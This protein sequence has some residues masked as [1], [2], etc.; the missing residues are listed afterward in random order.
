LNAFEGK[1]NCCF[2]DLLY[3]HCEH[4]CKSTQKQIE[5]AN[6]CNRAQECTVAL[7]IFSADCL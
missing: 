7:P 2:H 5:K 6:N 1:D 3:I 4:N